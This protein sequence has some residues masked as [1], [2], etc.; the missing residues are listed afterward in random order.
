MAETCGNTSCYPIYIGR[1]VTSTSSPPNTTL[2]VQYVLQCTNPPRLWRR[3]TTE[4][5]EEWV[6]VQTTSPY[7]FYDTATETLCTIGMQN[8]VTGTRG[9]DDSLVVT[10]VSEG[11]VTTG[12]DGLVVRGTH[13]NKRVAGGNIVHARV[14]RSQVTASDAGAMVGG[15]FIDGSVGAADNDAANVLVLARNNSKALALAQGSTVR[16]SVE[17][18]SVMQAGGTATL[19]NIPARTGLTL[20]KIGDNLYF[21]HNTVSVIQKSGPC[22]TTR[23]FVE[24]ANT[25][26][27]VPILGCQVCTNSDNDEHSSGNGQGSLVTAYASD[28][29]I[30]HT[31]GDGSLAIGIA[32]DCEAH[33]AAGL[34]SQVRGRGNIALAAYSDATGHG[35][36]AHMHGQYAQAIKC[37]DCGCGRCQYSRVLTHSVA[38]C[39]PV[40]TNGNITAFTITYYLVLGDTP[41]DPIIKSPD[42]TTITNY[43]LPSLA[44]PGSAAVTVDVV[45]PGIVVNGATVVAPSAAKYFFLVSRNDQNGCA[46]HTSSDIDTLSTTGPMPNTPTF[47]ANL[48]NNICNG[49]TLSFTEEIPVTITNPPSP[50]PRIASPSPVRPEDVQSTSNTAFTLIVRNLCATF[51]ITDTGSGYSHIVCAKPEP[52]PTPFV[53]VT[54]YFPPLPK[55]RCPEDSSDTSDESPGGVVGQDV[56]GDTGILE[57]CTSCAG[58]R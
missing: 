43:R 17:C 45:S 3:H 16:G 36:L 9:S 15:H 56:F 35:A 26:K 12:P 55:R 22:V 50:V 11:R 32:K 31:A 21:T 53:Q 4:D 7:I 54:P 20:A 29:S 37:G 57:E 42:G 1:R 5:T 51:K 40:V 49:Y 10:Q 52:R 18:N 33:V 23:Y 13:N 39:T 58:M 48:A 28:N 46:T 47:A 19:R 30:V 25:K 27:P 14:V 34:A 8:L 6:Q 44:C 41:D 38:T 2:D 24:K